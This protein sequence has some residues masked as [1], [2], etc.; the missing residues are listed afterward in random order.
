MLNNQKKLLAAIKAAEAKALE[1]YRAGVKL[2]GVVKALREA[3]KGLEARL[4]LL[5]DSPEAPEK[6]EAPENN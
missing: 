3:R 2:G 1:L 6:P 4:A 5:T